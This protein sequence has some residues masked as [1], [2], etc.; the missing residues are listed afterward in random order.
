M[1]EMIKIVMCCDVVQGYGMTESVGTCSKAVPWD[2]GGPGT[3][4]AFQPCNDAKVV[5]VVEMGVS[6][7][8]YRDL[9]S[10]KQYTS[11]DQPNPRGELC[12]RG[13]NITVGYLHDPEN[14]AKTIDK[15]GWLHTGDIAEIDAQGRLKIV[16]RIKNVLKL[17]QG[18]VTPSDVY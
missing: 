12:L 15:E 11:Q 2:I 1:H 5:D 18:S 3:C 13:A 9:G 7:V 17:A 6:V 8:V 10:H 16:D 4:G 14:T